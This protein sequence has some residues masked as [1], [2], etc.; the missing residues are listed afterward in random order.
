MQRIAAE[1]GYSETAFLAPDGSGEP[2]RWRVR[3]FS[4]LAEVP[5]CGHATIAAGVASR[6]RV[7]NADA[8]ATDPRQ[9]VLT[10]NDGEVA[11]SV[12][13]GRRRARDGDPHLGRAVGPRRA[14]RLLVDRT[15]EFLDWRL[16]ELDPSLPPA[17]A[18]AGARHLVLAVAGA[19][20]ARAGWRTG[21]TR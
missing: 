7:R 8:T 4:P 5:F 1:V 16:D 13:V 9:V 20:H 21:S 17:I 12:T 11:V 14:A 2:G 3:Y 15:L 19:G 10:T 18:F 6:G